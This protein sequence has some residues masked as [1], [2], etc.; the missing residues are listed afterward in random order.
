MGGSG[1]GYF[2]V[3]D[4][5]AQARAQNAD[6]AERRAARRARRAD[7]PGPRSDRVE[8]ACRFLCLDCGLLD[9]NQE[10]APDERCRACESPAIAD[11][12]SRAVFDSIKGFDL[13][14]R[15]QIPKE[16][17]VISSSIGGV[18]GGLASG[19]FMYA[20]GTEVAGLVALWAV[21]GALAGAGLGFGITRVFPD[22]VADFRP[23]DLDALPLRWALPLPGELSV[24][25]SQGRVDAC[26]D[27]LMAPFSG[28]PCAAWRVQ[29]L[30]DTPG[31][32]VPEQCILDEGRSAAFSVGENRYEAD[33]LIVDDDDGPKVFELE[34][35][36]L[37][38]FL[39][40]RGFD[41]ADGDFRVLE[42]VLLEGV[43]V[44]VDDGAARTDLDRVPSPA[45]NEPKSVEQSVKV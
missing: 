18:L 1:G 43:E 29:V 26:A 24:E 6:W 25:S 19:G 8:F 28:T 22:L 41:A 23:T 35:S 27:P 38:R 36:Q 42:W 40:Q 39:R 34:F 45:E 20:F 15:R 4:A 12:Q 7:G 10:R 5:V 3:R 30:F 11:L 21:P 17:S 33:R 9:D 2:A 32:A 37:D 44:F 14:R 31:D 16:A 13:D